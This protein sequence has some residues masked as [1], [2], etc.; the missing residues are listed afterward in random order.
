MKTVNDI[1]NKI[2]S[3]FFDEFRNLLDNPNSANT[4]YKKAIAIATNKL[5]EAMN[6]KNDIILKQEAKELIE[7]ALN[8][9][10]VV[11]DAVFYDVA[12]T[13]KQILDECF[14]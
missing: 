12:Q 11:A 10:R 3:S 9:N 6:N 2:Y 14:S 5:V 1:I 8:T 7:K 4:E 13:L